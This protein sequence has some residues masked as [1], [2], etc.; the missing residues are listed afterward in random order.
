M[1]HCDEIVKVIIRFRPLIEA[2]LNCNPLTCVEIEDSKVT[3]YGNGN[4][5][6]SFNFDRVLVSISSQEE[7]FNNGPEDVVGSVM[8]GFNGTIFTYGQIASG[9]T[10]TMFGDEDEGDKAGVVVRSINKVFDF[11]EQAEESSEF[12]IKVCFFELVCE[13]IYDLLNPL[14][15]GLKIRSSKRGTFVQ[16]VRE[17]YVTCVEDAR[18]LVKIGLGYQNSRKK[19]IPG[20]TIFTLDIQQ[21]CPGVGSLSSRLYLVDLAGVEKPSSIPNSPKSA[22]MK[23]LNS[24][25]S[26]LGMV[27]C[28]LSEKSSYIP[29][30]ASK[31]TRILEESLGGNSKTIFI[32]TCSPSPLNIEQTCNSLRF[33]IRLKSVKNKPKINK[34]LNMFELNI[35]Y[36]QKLEQLTQ[37]KRKYQILQYRKSQTISSLSSRNS[38]KTDLESP[39]LQIDYTE[40]KLE[41][42]EIYQRIDQQ[43]KIKLSLEQES[44]EN[45]KK[46]KTEEE[47][48]KKYESLVTELAQHCNMLDE[49][50]KETEENIEK[51]SAVIDRTK[52]EI[53]TEQDEI[54][55]L[56][57]KINAIA[58]EN[59]HFKC[60]LK[61]L[62]EMRSSIS[63]Q[64]VEEQLRRRIK[65]EKVNNKGIKSE[66]KKIQEE[67]DLL[68]FKR[69][70]EYIFGEDLQLTASKIFEL[71]VQIENARTKFL[72]DEKNL[73]GL[74]RNLK[75]KQD[76]LSKVADKVD[77]DYKDITVKHAQIVL[78][79]SIL[80]KKV[81]R[82]E[83]KVGGLESALEKVEKK[84]KKIEKF[85][86][87]RNQD[88]L[89]VLKSGSVRASIA[90]RQMKISVD[91]LFP[92]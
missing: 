17:V 15:N 78:E 74:Q 18:E 9:K 72:E 25:L 14:G 55:Q 40:L 62:K 3:V 58:S 79:K 43:Q 90:M 26:A 30:R 34:D 64:A 32:I 20:H 39:K 88:P 75:N 23:S 4:N 85:N 41:L 56:E 24:S 87:A 70:R 61:C 81:E 54:E 21:N 52:T 73:T 36:L 5:S 27:I 66:I 45:D 48:S 44:V 91:S 28:A 59:E 13:K 63:K 71:E 49:E 65:E 57:M 33:G 86:E 19:S 92:N 83:E 38:I 2:E 60:K 35:Q 69:F 82:L 68:L 22:S 8:K 76:V 67:I 1:N 37:L 89:K 51:S 11:V 12:L 29:Y 53:E 31:L 50:L 84:L 7:V 6:L 42:D 10:F 47:L 46:L 16:G 80:S 77:K